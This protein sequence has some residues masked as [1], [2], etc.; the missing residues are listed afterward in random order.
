M[1]SLS[2]LA[3][4]LAAFAVAYVFRGRFLEKQFDV[5][6]SNPTPAASRADG[7]D[8]V[9]AKNPFIL[10]GRHFWS[11]AGAGPVIYPTAGVIIVSGA[12]AFSGEEKKI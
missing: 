2:I 3:A 4:V 10:F 8:F 12:P 1:N 9:A 6:D 5:N 7:C 11:I